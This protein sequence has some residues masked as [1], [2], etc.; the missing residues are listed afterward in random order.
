MFLHCFAV[1]QDVIEEN[2][3]KFPQMCSK[4]MVHQSME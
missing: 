2:Q 3:H 1:D 4:N